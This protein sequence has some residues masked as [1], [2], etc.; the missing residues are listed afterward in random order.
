LTRIEPIRPQ[1]VFILNKIALIWPKIESKLFTIE[2]ILGQ[3]QS[4]CFNPDPRW[5]RINSKRFKMELILDHIK[6]KRFTADLSECKRSP[7]SG[8]SA[9][10]R[11]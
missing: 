6:A 7:C 9:E 1:T 4:I 3:I 10:R 8:V 2:T 11:H 5:P